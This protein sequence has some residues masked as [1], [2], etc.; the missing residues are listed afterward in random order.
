[1][2]GDL[3]R[4]TF[5]PLKHFTSIVLQQGRVQMD[6]DANEQTAILLHHLRS[7]AADLIGPHGGPADDILLNADR[8]SELRARNCGFAIIAAAGTETAPTF[9]PDALL[10]DEKKFLQ[11]AIHDNRLAL[12]IT[13]GHYY[14]D[15]R[16]CENETLWRYVDQPYLRRA[17]DEE[18]RK[19]TGTF[20]VYLDVW[21]RF[22]SSVDDPSLREVA[23][24][25]ADTAARM[26]LIWQVKV[27]T[28]PVDAPPNS[29]EGFN[30]TWPQIMADLD[31]AN[32]GNLRARAK[33]SEENGD[34]DVC[35]TSPEARYRGLENQLYRVEVHRGGPAMQSNEDNMDVAATFKWSRNNATNA[36]ALK[37]K[38]GDRLIVSGLRDFSRWFRP[39]DWVEV[40][41]D[42]LELRGL[43]GTMVRLAGVEGETLTIDPYT[44]SD[45]IPE[46]DDMFENL[47]IRNL[48]VRG[49]DHSQPEDDLLID[50]AIPIEEGQEIELEDGIMIEFQTGNPA[51]QYRSGDY[52]L[53]PAR[54][55]TG[56]VEWPQQ[57]VDPKDPANTETEPKAMPPNGIEHHFAP[58]A[59][60]TLAAGIVT[61]IV[62]L[63]H[64]FGPLARCATNLNRN[65]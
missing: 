27:G 30:D 43:P 50:G 39:G 45:T 7:M 62:D 54:V 35:I 38:N 56:D 51:A 3:S 20:L 40:T 61:Q 49:W 13:G 21:E 63:R 12:A 48:K 42:A 29:C 53:I 58:L 11:Q 32:R 16:L 23:L 9:F 10:E 57:R 4:V 60:V 15:G 31:P 44:T 19:L 26:K 65:V 47:P 59:A 41:H 33:G 22:V 5:N 34:E 2:N 52:W 37:E 64:V 6:S 55:A 17:N 14:V 36:V 28:E 25:G 46:P 1:M 24:G 18:I 8:V